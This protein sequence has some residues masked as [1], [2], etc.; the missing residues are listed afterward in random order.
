VGGDRILEPHV[1]ASALLRIAALFTRN[2]ILPKDRLQPG[3]KPG[4]AKR[5]ASACYTCLRD[6]SPNLSSL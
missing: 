3:S 2:P 5:A 1:G 4:D 6:K